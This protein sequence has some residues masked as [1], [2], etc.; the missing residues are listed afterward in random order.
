MPWNCADVDGYFSDA[1]RLIGF[2]NADA[3]QSLGSV[4]VVIAQSHAAGGAL[5]GTTSSTPLATVTI[6]GGMIGPNGSVRVHAKLNCSG[7]AGTKTVAIA[8]NG[9]IL[10]DTGYAAGATDIT[11]L[12]SFGNRGTL[13]SQVGSGAG[14]NGG[15]GSSTSG[16]L[17][18]AAQ[19]TAND[20][21]VTIVATLA[22]AADSITLQSYTV[23]V[24]PGA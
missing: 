13:S 18:T 20:L 9:S 8:L 16:A 15:L 14:I 22:N 12:L 17:R 21:A 1:G 3:A 11:V 6:P 7:V 5:T 19:N 23:E 24:I 10:G 2:R 4:P